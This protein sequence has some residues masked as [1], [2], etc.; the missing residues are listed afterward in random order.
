M[1]SVGWIL[2]FLELK[3]NGSCYVDDDCTSWATC[4]YECPSTEIGICTCEHSETLTGPNGAYICGKTRVTFPKDGAKRWGLSKT[5]SYSYAHVKRSLCR[6]KVMKIKIHD[7][8][9]N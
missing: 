8:K 4:V 5:R 6:S 3:V 9:N 7:I 2:F 1:F